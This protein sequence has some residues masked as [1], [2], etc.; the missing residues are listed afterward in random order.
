M[1]EATVGVVILELRK[2]GFA[3][4]VKLDLIWVYSNW[5]CGENKKQGPTGHQL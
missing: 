5:H 3:L 1:L 2:L 4:A